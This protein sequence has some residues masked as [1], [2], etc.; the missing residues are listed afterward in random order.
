[1]IR[2]I[3]GTAIDVSP[4]HVVVSVGG[5]GYLIYISTPPSAFLLNHEVSLW[6][7]LAVRE[8]ALDLYGFL[9]RDE[10]WFF[11]LLLTL[12]KIGPKSASQIMAAA[13][14]ELLKKAILENDAGYLSKLSGIGKKTAE[15]VVTGLQDKVEEM[16]VVGM[17][18]VAADESGTQY[19]SDAIDALVS[20]GYPQSDARRAVQQ[21]PA[22]VTNANE[23]VRAALKSLGS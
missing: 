23:A 16:G 3:T 22:S 4:T 20:L 19:M 13:D 8:N 21:L 11:E 15:K 1:M 12:P 5:V 14:L 6:T 2:Q 18:G 17:A 7:H 10:L 9:T